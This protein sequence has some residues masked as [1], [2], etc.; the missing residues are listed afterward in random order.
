MQHVTRRC[1]GI[2]LREVTGHRLVTGSR[3]RGPLEDPKGP[4]RGH[5]DG[6]AATWDGA[7][8]RPCCASRWRVPLK[9]LYLRHGPLVPTYFW[10]LLKHDALQ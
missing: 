1:T 5:E 3:P 10:H 4:L 2:G 6:R 9:W 8:G 7:S